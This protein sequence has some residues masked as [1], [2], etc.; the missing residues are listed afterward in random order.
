MEKYEIKNEKNAFYL[1][2]KSH[3]YLFSFGGSADL[4]IYKQN[5]ISKGSCTQGDYN[6]KGKRNVLCG[7][8][9]PNTFT[10]K[11]FIFFQMK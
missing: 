10:P 8:Q 2:T 9:Y 11:R 4:L 6:Y 7:K 5:E 1:N 3:Q